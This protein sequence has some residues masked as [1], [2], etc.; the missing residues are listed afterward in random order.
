M[1]TCRN[2]SSTSATATAPR[3]SS[4]AGSTPRRPRLRSR[5]L[6]SAPAAPRGLAAA[7][8]APWPS[9][10]AGVRSLQLPGP[11]AMLGQD[12]SPGRELRSARSPQGL[13]WM[14]VRLRSPGEQN[15]RG[16]VAEPPS[17][18]SPC[19][20]SASG[21]HFEGLSLRLPPC[22]ASAKWRSGGQKPAD[23]GAAAPRCQGSRGARCRWGKGSQ[24]RDQG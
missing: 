23:V 22:P 21:Q 3:I 2:C 1:A 6:L 14:P 10:L 15:L 4:Q 9:P 16:K 24:E 13:G 18:F 12:A 11:S 8:L 7:P 20:L 5:P 19:F 17:N